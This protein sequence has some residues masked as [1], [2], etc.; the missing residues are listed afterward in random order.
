[1]KNKT[2][3]LLILLLIASLG[4]CSFVAYR[5]IDSRRSLTVPDFLGKSKETAIEWC[6]SL[7]PNYSCEIQYEQSTSTEKDHVFY[8]S[9]SAGNKMKDN[10]V[11]KVSTGLIAQI[12]L[13]EINEN[14]TREDI[15]A[16]ELKNMMNNVKYV[17]E[18]SQTV[19]RNRIIHMLLRS[20]HIKTNKSKI[21]KKKSRKKKQRKTQSLLMISL[22]Q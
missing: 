13:P 17:E 1:M 8:Q 21:S 19:K 10:L 3:L 16:W 2:N 4:L 5:F 9:I 12:E 15:E 7:D 11:L 18:E 20:H 14:T 6:G 22:N